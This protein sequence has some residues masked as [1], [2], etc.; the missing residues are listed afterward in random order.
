MPSVFSIIGSAWFFYKK[1]PV[2]NFVAFWFFFLPPTLLSLADKF[3]L[4][5]ALAQESD[6]TMTVVMIIAMIVIIVAI[7]LIYTWGA[8]CILIVGKRMIM[9]NKAGRNRTS[10]KAIRKQAKRFV[11]PMLLTEILGSCFTIL[12]GLLLIIPGVIYSVRIA[13]YDIVM[14]TE[15]KYYRGAL[16]RS[17]E[18]VRGQTW[19][20]FLYLLGIGIIIFVPIS[21]IGFVVGITTEAG[22]LGTS[23]TALF[24]IE[25]IIGALYSLATVIFLLASIKLFGIVKEKSQLPTP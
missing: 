3:F 18:Y 2:L 5:E 24:I 22:L 17:K 11:I 6:I 15:E 25:I 4:A 16:N 14:I 13:F 7:A 20:V 12:W 19:R 8:A 23:H 9:E 1:H 21:L 10:F